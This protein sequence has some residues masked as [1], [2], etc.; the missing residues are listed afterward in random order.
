MGG[1]FGTLWPAEGLPGR[2][3][4]YREG[5]PSEARQQRCQYSDRKLVCNLQFR[6]LRSV[7]VLTNHRTRDDN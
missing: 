7:G 5:V 1:I 6:V 3:G 2:G 4:K